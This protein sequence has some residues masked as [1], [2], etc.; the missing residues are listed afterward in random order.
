MRRNLPPFTALKAFDAAAKHDNFKMAAEDAFITPSAISHQI[1]ILEDYLGFQLFIRDKGF[2][3]L[4]DRGLDYYN[5]IK[6]LFDTLE[7]ATQDL[8]IH[9]NKS[10]IVINLFHSFLS[11]WLYEK[12]PDF[13]RKNPDIELSFISSDNPPEYDK[14]EFDVAIYFGQ[15]PLSGVKSI[16]LFDDYMT[17][18]TSP[19]IAKKLPSEDNIFDLEKLPFL[20]CTCETNEWEVW[21][22]LFGQHC[23]KEDYQLSTNDRSMVLNGAAHNMGIAIGRQPFMDKY[24]K[25]G[26]LIIPYKKYID[27]GYKYYIT[28]H[29]SLAKNE[30]IIVFEK[31]LLTECQKLYAVD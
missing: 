7:Q 4:T 10:K 21:F 13:Q 3:R 6:S 31:W 11:S 26:T 12:L 24:L 23:P 25:N 22:N 8:R 29:K 18:V 15:K 30:N 1:K 2:I 27:T 9:L 17:M 5:Q 19:E 20:H 16:H 14:Y 28:Y